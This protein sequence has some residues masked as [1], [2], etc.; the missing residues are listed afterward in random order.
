MY[1]IPPFSPARGA[2]FGGLNEKEGIL[3]QN[4]LKSEVSHQVASTSAIAF[5]VL[6]DVS[7]MDFFSL[8]SFEVIYVSFILIYN[9]LL[10]YFTSKIFQFLVC[11][12]KKRQKNPFDWIGNHDFLFYSL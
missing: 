7:F 8:L 10:L 4:L 9:R 11:L 6:S 3:M 12:L 5:N 2:V 1:C